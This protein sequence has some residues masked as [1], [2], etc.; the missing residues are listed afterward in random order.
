MAQAAVAASRPFAQGT[1]QLGR[2]I[3]QF[4]WSAT[5]LG[6]IA[7]WPAVVRNTVELM[8]RSPVP[9]VTMWGAD[10]VMIYNDGYAEIA[11]ER[12]PQQLGAPVRESWPD[13]ADFNDNVMRICLAGGTL[14]Y[15]D[16]ELNLRRHGEPEQVW[17]NLDYSPVAAEDGSV[18]GVLALLTETT[19]KVRA[20]RY[21]AGEQ[22]RL[23]A[24]FA[25]APGFMAMLLGPEHRYELVNE[26]YLGL[27][28]RPD[29]VGRTVRDVLPE[30]AAQGFLA[31][32]DRVYASGQ[33]HTGEATEIWLTA[34]SGESCLHYLDF[35]FQPV[36]EE[37]G[38]VIGIFV[39]GN[40]VTERVLAERA[41]RES[42]ARFRTFAQAMPN[43]VWGADAQGRLDWFN[44]KIYSYS[45]FS[46]ADL[47]ADGWGRM[48]HPGDLHAV[49]TRWTEAVATG[50][51]F[52]ADVRLRR[53]DGS[54]RWHLNRAVPLRGEHGLVVGWVG[55]NTDIEEQKNTAQRYAAL[56]DD[57]QGQV[58]LRTAERDRMW[59][60][61]K[62]I[63]MVCAF[64]GRVEAVSPAFGALL[65]WSETD[66]LG[67]NFLE[68]VHLE[69]RSA[70]VAQMAA[71]GRGAYVNKF[72][73][74]YRRKDGSWCLLSWTASPDE[75]YVHAIGR[76]ITADREQVE[77]IRRTE[78]ALQQSQKMETIGKLTGGV[79]HD[80]NNLLQ[81][82]SGNLQ[83]L[84]MSGVARSAA[85]PDCGRWIEN[86]RLA[87]DKGAKLASYLLAFGRRQPL[88]PKVI[89]ISRLVSNMEDLL[90]RSL[91]EEIEIE[92]VISG[93]LWNTAVDVAQVENAL[94]NLAINAR[95]A[96]EGSGRM[97]I[98]ATN[99]V[100][101]DLY[102]R[103]HGDVIPGQYVMLAVSDTGCG[104]PPEVANRAF[105]PFFSTKE[106]GKGT[107]LG[108]SMVYGF[109]KQSGGHVKIYS[110]I[111]QGTTVKLYLPR[112]TAAEEP[113]GPVE[114]Q[115]AVGGSETILVA[116]DDEAVRATVV[117][118]LSGL[119]YR[120]LKAPDAASA[121]AVIDSGVPI[122]LLFTDVV[123]PGR[124]RSPEL[125]RMARERLPN[126]A[127]L[128]TSGYTE[129]AIVHGGRLDPGV[130]LLGKPY[131]RE[132]LA[133]RIRQVL[134]NQKRAPEAP[135]APPAPP[136]A[137]G[138]AIV[139]VEDEE[140]I[141]TSTAALLEHLGHRVQSAPD[142]ETALPMISAATDVLITD[143]QLP[144]MWG[145]ALAAQAR[146]NAPGVR[147][148]FATGNGEVANW[149]DAVVLRKPY[150]LQ[151]LMR[152]LGQQAVAA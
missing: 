57:L 53:H 151:S 125:A 76:D 131:T 139:L 63:L 51:V 2:L 48:I 22:D 152:V 68:L 90:R 36:R 144:G 141:R 106:E 56:N 78:L 134:A 47:A 89:R 50:T 148:V 110:E 33:S 79:A 72:E 64:D 55:T 31:L 145:D 1:G 29:V 26:A 27:V 100:L 98:E 71:L 77:T 25:Q 44:E 136:K 45:G 83:L 62:D 129:N 111:G 4:D 74:R 115:Q 21:L 137:S 128:F 42:E 116:E 43:Q 13:E 133:R 73:N 130:E 104:M 17:L 37:G 108:L 123:M 95:D 103:A 30:V 15:R 81:I 91:G 40:D 132:R 101:D 84:Q 34:A 80:F 65:G 124:L 138:L 140:N 35:V 118:M 10:G 16:A 127:V 60:L 117:E 107:G 112:S 96:M 86:A 8:L 7:G 11:A 49:R 109:V 119:G 3:E 32:L 39:Q 58:A 146:S 19:A 61:S 59:R 92:M 121:L 82:I 5:S 69:D 88:E 18:L 46:H 93:G 150:D 114:Q 67:K 24:M 143:V 12:H 28:D 105:E 6:P 135:P 9:M 120:V 97:T 94:L 147:I 149:P 75:R 14:C 41:L 113:L 66:V 122:D 102:C 70:T 38:A 52:E 23:R 126:L 99:A 54:Y 87:V 142:A 20:E 85:N